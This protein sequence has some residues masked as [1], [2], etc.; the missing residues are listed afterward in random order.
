MHSA[1]IGEDLRFG[2]NPVQC[3]RSSCWE[4]MNSMMD[5]ISDLRDRPEYQTDYGPAPVRTAL[6]SE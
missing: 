5:P 1:C 3:R 2:L 6:A 4:L